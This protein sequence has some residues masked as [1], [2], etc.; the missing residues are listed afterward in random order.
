MS[1]KCL[2]L[3]KMSF[4]ERRIYL[5]ADDQSRRVASSSISNKPFTIVGSGKQTRDFTY[6]SDV[7]NAFMKSCESSIK[8]EISGK[9]FWYIVFNLLS[10]ITI[11]CFIF[12]FKFLKKFRKKIEFIIVK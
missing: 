7:V 10:T 11:I 8:N 6:V 12:A 1:E 3:V 2:N 4:G 9:D 5:M